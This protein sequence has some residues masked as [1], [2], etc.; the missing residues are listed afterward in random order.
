M[1]KTYIGSPKYKIIQK[2]EI[3]GIVDKEDIIGAIFGQSEGLLGEDLDLRELQK[4]GKIGRIEIEEKKVS[5]KTRGTLTVPSSLDMVQTS[6]L[7]AAIESVDKVGP[8]QAKF[9]TIQIEDTRSEKRKAITSRAQELLKKM[10]EEEV[11]ETSAL[12]ESVRE[13]LKKSELIEFGKEKLAA[14]PEVETSDSIIIVEGRAD[15]LTLLKNN[16]KNVIAINGSKIPKTIIE[17][18]KKKEATVF[19]DGDRGGELIARE[20][21][22]LAEIDFIARAPDGKEVEELTRK[23]IVMCLRKKVPVEKNLKPVQFNKPAFTQKRF[24]RRQ[25]IRTSKGFSRKVKKIVKRRKRFER[26]N[27]RNSLNQPKIL[28]ELP[29][30]PVSEEDKQAFEPLLNELKGTLEAR[31][32]DEKN[33]EI[34]RVK[35]RNLLEELQRLKGVSTI[36]FDGIIT[37]RLVEEAKKHGVKAIVGVKKG[38]VGEE[39][40]IKIIALK[41]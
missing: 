23:E 3:D 26:F 11:P 1:A 7:A 31:L 21:K 36:V 19:V 15:V 16:I 41:P 17:L 22:E 33:K 9:E 20:L 10:I 25:R 5:G 12:A 39:K 14:G 4:N 30:N 8:C 18:C 6:M 28:Q 35:V 29:L 34:K 37:K 38:K 13:E 27:Q 24:V 2:F 40:D 32:F